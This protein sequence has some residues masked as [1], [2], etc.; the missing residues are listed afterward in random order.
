V[1][2]IVV[3]VGL[4]LAQVYQQVG[5]QAPDVVSAEKLAAC[6]AMVQKLNA[7]GK[8]LAYHDR[9]DGGLVTTLAEMCFASHVGITLD[10]DEL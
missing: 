4:L 7:E 3:W 1:R 5:N 10:I 2:A 6:F 9:S 8:I